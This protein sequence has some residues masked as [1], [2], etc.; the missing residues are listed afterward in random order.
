MYEEFRAVTAVATKLED[1][2][3]SLDYLESTPWMKN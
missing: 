1:M 3:K 2:I